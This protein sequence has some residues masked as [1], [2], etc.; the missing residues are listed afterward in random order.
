MRLV[1]LNHGRLRFFSGA[2]CT[3]YRLILKERTVSDDEPFSIAEIQLSRDQDNKNSREKLCDRYANLVY[4]IA[5]G[6]HRHLLSNV[7]LEDL[8]AYGQTGLL[9]AY[10]R[11]DGDYNVDFATYAYYRIRGEILD[12]C[13]RAGWGLKS[14]KSKNHLDF[15]DQTILNEFLESESFT[16]EEARLLHLQH[17]QDENQK[18][19]E[20]VIY[21]HNIVSDA[22]LVVLLRRSHREQAAQHAPSQARHVEK[23]QR[24][25][26]I[27]EHVKQLDE[28]TQEII[29]CYYYK[30]L[31]MQEIADKLQ[32]SKSWV[33]RLHGRALKQLNKSL[34]NIIDTI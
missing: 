22:A 13:R 8:I 7:L 10:E 1:K 5:Q 33:C 25:N 4:K 26:L 2:Y 19:H 31:S 30:E 18:L 15:E 32:L 11:F 23:K 29:Y 12:A 9:E 34:A 24:K 14:K 17:Y 20:C 28:T 3:E 16:R 6:I 21:L 27:L